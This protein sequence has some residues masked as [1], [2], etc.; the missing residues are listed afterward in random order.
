MKLA[1]ILGI[2]VFPL[3]VVYVLINICLCISYFLRISCWLQIALDM[4]ILKT[5]GTIPHKRAQFMCEI[6][7][8]SPIPSQRLDTF[9]LQ[10]YSSLMLQIALNY[11]NL[12]FLFKFFWCSVRQINHLSVLSCELWAETQI[13]IL[14]TRDA[15]F[16]RVRKASSPRCHCTDNCSVWTCHRVWL[17]TRKCFVF[18]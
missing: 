8:F 10:P 4:Q 2:Q 6:V 13:C 1:L 16:L 15:V 9:F 18:F 14:N 3:S 17:W 12:H 7:P 5:F 11:F